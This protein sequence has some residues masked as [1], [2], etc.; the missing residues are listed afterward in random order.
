MGKEIGMLPTDQLKQG[1]GHSKMIR[2]RQSLALCLGEKGFCPLTLSLSVL[3]DFLTW[4]VEGIG[5]RAG[6]LGF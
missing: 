3:G 5:F 2:Q 1:P 6:S 4:E